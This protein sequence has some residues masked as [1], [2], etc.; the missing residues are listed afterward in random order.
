MKLDK[1]VHEPAR[2]RIMMVLS[3][4]ESADF[5]FLLNTLGVTRGN[6]SSH[7][8]KLER[9]G[10]ITI[11]KTFIG[12]RPNTSFKLTAAGKNALKIYWKNLDAV[13]RLGHEKD[14]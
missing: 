12:K 7:T 9:A 1:I 6:L 10:Y 2:L 8:E 3:G 5:N 14:D 13:R 4:V 11:E